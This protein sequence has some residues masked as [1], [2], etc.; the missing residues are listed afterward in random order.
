MGE[1]SDTGGHTRYRP[2]LIWALRRGIVDFYDRLGLTVAGSLLMMAPVAVAGLIAP[3]IGRTGSP[4]LAGALLLLI[5]WYG[6]GLGWGM[7]VLQA[8]RIAAYEDPGTHTF[9]GFFRSFGPE[10]ARLL[11][12]QLIVTLILVFD[13]AL[14]V[15]NPSALFR[16]AG[17][18]TGY[19]LLLWTMSMLWHWPFMVRGEQGIWRIL[20]KSGLVVLDNPFF[21]LGAL[22]IAAVAAALL[23]M[24]GIGFLVLGGALACFVVRAHR[25]IL[26]KYDLEEDEPPLAADEGWP[27]SGGPPRRLNPRWKDEPPQGSSEGERDS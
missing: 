7:N 6:A 8:Q 3:V 17:I 19:I 27:G 5:S 22:L 14:F 18:V 16:A 11:S 26:K 2:R 15:L 13:T 9:A 10:A 21:S 23:M 1:I 12:V 4:L 24:S 25:E 20:K